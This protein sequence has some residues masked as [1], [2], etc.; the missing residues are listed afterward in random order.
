MF[1][2]RFISHFRCLFRH[3]IALTGMAIC[4]FL[5]PLH[6]QNGRFGLAAALGVNA[7]QID[8]D[9]SF[10]YNKWGINVGLRGRA[11]LRDNWE[12]QTGI[13]YSQQGSQSAFLSRKPWNMYIDLHYILVPLEIHFKDWLQ[14]GGYHKFHFFAGLQ[15]GRLFRYQI[16]DGGLGLPENGYRPHD[17]SWLAG[18]QYQLNRQLGI[19][20]RYT[21]SFNFLYDKTSIPG[22]PYRSML[23]YFVSL[24]LVYHI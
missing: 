5:L 13:Q 22:S 9:Q 4:F 17:F 3:Q 24:H 11:Y 21:R 14:E 15:Y 16:Q 20:L 10:G 23:G 7:S 2:C 8:G 12:L 6:S 19:A 1:F 18:T